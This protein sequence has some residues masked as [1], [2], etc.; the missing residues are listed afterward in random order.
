MEIHDDDPL[1]LP[2]IRHSPGQADHGIYQMSVPAVRS[3]PPDAY[4]GAPSYG[5]SP[6]VVWEDGTAPS[7]EPTTPYLGGT[8]VIQ[9]PVEEEVVYVTEV[10]APVPI[11]ASSAKKKEP[12]APNARP[13][14]THPR[15]KERQSRP[16][17]PE[18]AP[19][20]H[21][22]LSPEEPSAGQDIERIL[23]K[24]EEVRRK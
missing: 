16:A 7:G 24:I 21:R 19:P 20:H 14:A 6:P 9:R 13:L 18:K 5:S 10:G 15:S 17:S 2:M 4:A 12:F 3:A 11:W 8:K 1:G 22:S 23:K